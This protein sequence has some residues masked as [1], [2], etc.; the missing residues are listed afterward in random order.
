LLNSYNFAFQVL[1]EYVDVIVNQ[2]NVSM[3]EEKEK[4]AIIKKLRNKYRLT[5]SNEST[6]EEALSFRLSRLNVFTVAGT[7]LIVLIALITV[8][9][10]FT[11][12]RE[13]IPGYPDGKMRRSIEQNMKS[14]DSLTT[15]LEKRDRFF[16]GIKNVVSGNDFENTVQSKA[17]SIVDPKYKGLQFTQSENDSIFRKDHEAEEKFNL[18]ISGENKA[19]GVSSIHFFTPMKGMISNSYDGLSGHYGVDV[20]GPKNERISAVLD[21]TV[22]FAEWTLNTGYV[23][24]IQ[25]GKDLVSIYKHNQE[26]LKKPGEFVK[27]G[28][29][30]AILGNSGELTSGPHLHFELWHNGKALNPENYIKF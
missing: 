9:I 27:A 14:V 8:L 25:H 1:T 23:V 17:D 22:I 13:Y 21:G 12:L 16:Q 28:E 5:V 2:I 6:F 15:E 24:Q 10:A 19:R 29:A 18:T 26:L 4:K 3:A 20:V 11:P 7:S 30:I